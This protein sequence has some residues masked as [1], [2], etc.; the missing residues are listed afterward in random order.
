M[1]AAAIEEGGG[2]SA[3]RAKSSAGKGKQ[4]GGGRLAMLLVFALV[5]MMPVA[6]ATFTI[7]AVY[8]AP[9]WVVGCFRGIQTPGAIPTVAGLNVAGVMPA[10]YHLWHHGNDFEAALGLL[11]DTEFLVINFAAAG[12][13]VAML[14]IAPFIAHTW[15][16]IAGQRLLRRAQSEREKLMD[17][18]GEALE[19]PDLPEESEEE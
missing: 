4:K 11:F 9:T 10:L 3:A 12:L 15:V 8:M 5:C 1:S 13:G 2:K 17:E 14:L 18:W 16:D 7:V 19:K 6:P